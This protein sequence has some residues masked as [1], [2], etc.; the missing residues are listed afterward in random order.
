MN[1]II[2]TGGGTAGHIMPNVA[3]LPKL[4]NHFQKIIY[5]GSCNG[6]EKDII[7]Q[8]SFVDFYPITTTKLIR[9][10][11]LKNLFIPFKLLKG[12][13]QAKRIIKKTKPNVI[14]SK[15]GFV[16]LPVVLAASKCKVPVVLHESDLSMGLSNKIAAKKAKCVL[17]TFPETAEQ[18]KNGIFVGSPI[19][20]ELFNQSPIQVNQQLNIKTTKPIL[21]ILGG[22]LGSKFLNELVAQ[23]IDFLTEHF[24]VIHLIGKQKNTFKNHKDYVQFQF[25]KQIEK[26]YAI[27]D[28]AITR[29][30]SNTIWE[31]FALKIPMLII[32]LGTNVSRGDQIQNATYFKT[33][34]FALMLLENEATSENIK[35]S[36]IK[37]K[38]NKDTFK[39]AMEKQ[40]NGNNLDKILDYIC[41]FATKK[42]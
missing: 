23:N 40:S 25:C 17:T 5:I 18:I 6:L 27:T 22:S 9:K 15:G 1:T 38:T 24:F 8:H 19:R 2:L 16:S 36:L 29:G 3:L 30:G 35:Q 14:F 26:L 7:S 37:L 20:Q 39:K 10:F 13:R 11:T 4:K 21:L 32:P 41:K 12:I 42:A 34:N 31:L 33:H 28:F